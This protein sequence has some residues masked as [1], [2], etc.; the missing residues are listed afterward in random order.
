MKFCRRCGVKIE[1][2]DAV[3]QPVDMQELAKAAFKD[4]PN[5]EVVKIITEPT[6][7]EQPPEH[8]DGCFLM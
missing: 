5:V 7:P 8:P 1:A 4:D 2:I 3:K 6:K